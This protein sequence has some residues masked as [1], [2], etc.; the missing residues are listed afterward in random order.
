MKTKEI[1]TA[2]MAL[3]TFF[4]FLVVAP[5]C[6]KDESRSSELKES[7]AK[8]IDTVKSKSEKATGEATQAATTEKIN[9]NNADLETLTNFEGIGPETAQNIIDYRKQVGSFEKVE[10]LLQV[11]GIGEKTLNAIKPFLRLK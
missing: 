8:A 2:T 4:V 3:L 11:K 9:I 7:A 6:A 5:V 1:V 10:D